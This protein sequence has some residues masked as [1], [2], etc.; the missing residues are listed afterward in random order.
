MLRRGRRK[1]AVHSRHL[2]A[3]GHGLATTASMTVSFSLN[4][5][6]GTLRMWDGACVITTITRRADTKER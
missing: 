4:E 6:D 2:V 1:G 5:L 3:I